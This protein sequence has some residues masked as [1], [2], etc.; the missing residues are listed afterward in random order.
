[1]LNHILL[2]LSSGMFSF[3]TYE[4]WFSF[5]LW[6]GMSAKA[7]GSNVSNL[8]NAVINSVGD[9]IISV[10]LIEICI[11]LFTRSI[12]QKWNWYAFFFLFSLANIQN[13]IVTINI[14]S[15]LKHTTL[16]LSPL[17]PIRLATPFLVQEAW[18]IYPFILYGFLIKTKLINK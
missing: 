7:R 9:G 5:G 2:F 3:I 12:F 13:I 1:M 8:T 15:R 18:I 14:Y 10:L 6:G 11:L 16:S 4:M 17:T